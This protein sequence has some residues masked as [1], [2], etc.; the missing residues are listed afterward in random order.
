[1][2]SKTIVSYRLDYTDIFYTP[3]RLSPLILIGKQSDISKHSPK[4]LL[5]LGLPIVS[6]KIGNYG[7]PYWIRTN[8]VKILS[9]LSPGQLD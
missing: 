2:A 7:V 3:Y 9:L 6:R 8:T 4:L 1:M 5:L